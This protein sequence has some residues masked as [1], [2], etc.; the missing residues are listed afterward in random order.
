MRKVVTMLQNI[1]KKVEGEGEMAEELFDKFA[2]ECNKEEKSLEQQIAAAQTKGSDVAAALAEGKS[3]ATQLTQ[4][5]SQAKKD[6]DAAKQA[7]ESATGI[8]QKEAK[9]FAAM[10]AES[11]A[12]IAA[13]GK[14]IKAIE[15]GTAAAFIQSDFSQKI[16]DIVQAQVEVGSGTDRDDVMA[17]LSGEEGAES[18]GEILGILKQLKEDMSKDLAEAT[19]D[20]QG[21]LATYN[22]LVEAKKKEIEAL[23]A[24]I[25][26]KLARLG[27]LGVANAEME[28]DGGDTGDSLGKDKQL[29]SDLKSQCAKRQ[30]EWELEKKTRGEELLALADTIKM[31]NDDDALEL[32]KKTL[33]SSAASF[34]QVKV[35]ASMMRHRALAGIHAAQKKHRGR[36]MMKLDFIALA[37]HGKKAGLEKVA[38]MIDKMMATL[39]GEQKEDDDKRDYCGAE[40]DKAD[41]EK[42]ALTR[43]V[44]DAQTAIEDAQESVSTITEEIKAIKAG[45]A[46]LDGSV[47][48]ATA[49]RQKENSAY[50]QLMAENGAAKELITLAKKRLNKFY[51]PKLALA[52]IQA[53]AQD[54]DFEV[55][56]VRRAAQEANGV[57][58]MMDTLVRDLDRE[59]AVA[60]TEEKN[61][62]E[63]Y[64]KTMADSKETRAA[65]LKLLEEKE[66]AKADSD[67][68]V[69]T[70]VD[71]KMAQ[72]K[73]LHGVNGYIMGLH[74]DCDW[75]LK[76]YDTR[77]GARADEIDA[78]DKAK[79]VLN[80]ADYSFLQ[81]SATH[82]RLRGS[83]HA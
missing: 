14:A 12:N 40:L 78:L 9:A 37:L 19:S 61:G 59:M 29:L 43:K 7:V 77:K 50:K 32:F 47:A 8:R 22:E 46:E 11:S 26:E 45:L 5:I 60:E 63:D 80:G 70:N 71:E 15:A 57:I 49:Q 41:D 1:V 24:S 20:E 44:A 67:A 38:A 58:A 51:N 83:H 72:A 76:N 31:L 3:Q 65:N 69:Q 28:N 23:Q 4:D 39:A 33:P 30:Q 13:M 64:E 48:I 36:P 55:D 18:S 42:K 34:M 27:E 52:Q 82:H 73:E 21:S 35:T 81:M 79:A 17:F 62:Q 54:A 10:K 68:A 75:L 6:R 25:E 2:C 56:K 16:K 74:A 66:S 53:H